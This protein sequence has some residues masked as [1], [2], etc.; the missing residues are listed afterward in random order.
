MA[1]K[2]YNSAWQWKQWANEIESV[3]R[4]VRA[5]DLERAAFHLDVADELDG[6]LRLEILGD[7]LVLPEDFEPDD[8][9]TD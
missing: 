1:R 6:Q 8:H 3:N 4:A 5:G 2:G 7:D 9:H